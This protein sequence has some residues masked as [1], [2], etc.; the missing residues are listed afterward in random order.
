MRD[1]FSNQLEAARQNLRTLRAQLE[2]A[3][4]CLRSAIAEY[5]ADPCEATE[6]TVATKG[7]SVCA[8]EARIKSGVD[9]LDAVIG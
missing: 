9:A 5:V 3:R 4:R 7:A 2:T 6:L 1:Q 8:I